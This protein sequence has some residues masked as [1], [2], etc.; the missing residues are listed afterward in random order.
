LRIIKIKQVF[1]KLIKACVLSKKDNNLYIY[2]IKNQN[3]ISTWEYKATLAGHLQYISA[4][5]WHPKTNLII[6]SSHD[7]DI[8]VWKNQNNVWIPDLVNLKVK[9][10]I[11]DVKW[12]EKG[13]KFVATTGSKLVAVGYYANEL[14]CWNCKSIKEHNSS[15]T[16]AR[17]DS[18]GLF[19][20][21]GSTD[22]KSYIFS[23]Y[24]PEVDGDISNYKLP[25]LELV[26]KI[27]IFRISLV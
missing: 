18:S 7:R 21:S 4:I 15:V 17:F 9:V 25:P 26:I 14:D 16:C 1:I 24:I 27:F 10:S 20:I 11:L 2:D 23:A 12:N 3:D 22:L 5:D 8:L 6:S 13:D 19:V